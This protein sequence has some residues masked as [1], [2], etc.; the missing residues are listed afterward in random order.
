MRV[1]AVDLVSN[2]CFPALAAEELGFFKAEGLD[3]HVE[4]VPMLGATKALRDGTADAMVAG[5]VHDLLTEFPRWEGAKLIVALSQG[6]PWLLVVRAGLSAKRGD[7]RA[8][9]GLRLAAAEGPDL[10]LRQMLIEAKVDPSHYLD[11]VYD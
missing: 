11:T 9:K 3:A 2:T 5:S 8:L 6:T 1:A 10:A 7:L 4:L